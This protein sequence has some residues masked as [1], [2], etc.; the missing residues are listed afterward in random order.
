MEKLLR[1]IRKTIDKEIEKY[2]PRNHNPKVLSDISWYFL[3][4]GGKRIRPA[5][6]LFSCQA[7]NGNSK[8]A[9][10]AA[11]AMELIHSSLLIHDDIL[12]FSDQRRGRLAVY[13]KFGLAHGVNVGD[14]FAT[15]SYEC[16]ASGANAWGHEKTIKVLEL[17]TEMTTK[18]LEGQAMDIDQRDKDLSEATMEWYE[19]MALRKTGYYTGGSP[20]AIGAVI[21]GGNE[22]E[23]EVLKKFGFGIG[24]ANQIIDDVLDVTQDTGQDFGADLKEGK[25]TLLTIHAFSKAD[26]KDRE[27]LKKL[28]GKKDITLEEKKEII[29][30]YRRFGSIQFAKNYAN[31]LVEDAI[32]EIEN[33]PNSEGREKLIELANF[34]VERRI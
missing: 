31:K 6:L 16:L 18:T 19:D 24:I 32:K 5:L 13:K 33:V 21:A 25:R 30:I 11:V 8:K 4:S 34:F 15:K 14:Y 29:E 3:D 9:I 1:D 2:L 23:I 26:K 20:C 12:D 28:I 10:P 7:I 27:K 17:M 22:K